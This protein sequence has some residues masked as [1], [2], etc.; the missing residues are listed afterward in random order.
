MSLHDR[1]LEE[2]K[3]PYFRRVGDG[4]YRGAI[5]GVPVLLVRHKLGRHQWYHT[6]SNQPHWIAYHAVEGGKVLS[7]GNGTMKGAIEGAEQAIRM[8]GL[9]KP[10]DIK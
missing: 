1:V 6:Y 8:R 2:G 10:E 3:R 9:A 7:D 5:H 4:E